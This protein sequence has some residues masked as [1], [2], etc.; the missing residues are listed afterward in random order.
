MEQPTVD[1]DIVEALK[2]EESLREIAERVEAP[3]SMTTRSSL[4]IQLHYDAI[5]E[6]ISVVRSR[7]VRG[8]RATASE[9]RPL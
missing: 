7:F 1:A 2:E 8:T 5:V 4:R 9:S 3:G 6:R